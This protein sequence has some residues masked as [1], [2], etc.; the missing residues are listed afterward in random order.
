MRRAI[1][2]VKPIAVLGVMA[3]AAFTGVTVMTAQAQTSIINTASFNGDGAAVM[4]EGYRKW[5]FVGAPLTPNALNGGNAPFPEY[6]NVYVEPSAFDAYESTGEWPEGTQLVK[7]LTTV[8]ENDND[9][10]GASMEVSGRGF[11][12]G[13]FSGLELAVKNTA[14]FP[15]MPGGW[16]YFSFGHQ[17]EPYEETATAFPAE[18]CNACHAEN[19]ADDFVFTQFYPVLR[20]A[21]ASK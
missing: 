8:Y 3:A 20:A 5:V 6:H 2:L 11:Q 17:P 19:A 21:K 1:S 15:D 7:E 4:P 9:E 10:V 16:A 13:E 14:L 18:T 12:Q